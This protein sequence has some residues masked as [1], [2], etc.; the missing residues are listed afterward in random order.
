MRSETRSKHC[1]KHSIM[2]SI[3]LVTAAANLRIKFAKIKCKQQQTASKHTSWHF[4]MTVEE[5]RPKACKNS[6]GVLC[7]TTTADNKY[8]S[9]VMHFNILKCMYLASVICNMVCLY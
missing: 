9:V 2:H 4:Y 1:E 8:C 3:Q 7:I 5:K 6:L